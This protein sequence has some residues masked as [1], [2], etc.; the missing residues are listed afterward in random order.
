MWLQAFKGTVPLLKQ[1]AKP[2]LVHHQTCLEDVRDSSTSV[3]GCDVL[4]P[5]AYIILFQVEGV[6][7]GYTHA[8]TLNGACKSR[9]CELV[10]LM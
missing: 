7:V 10:I 6:A 2:L 4:D 3:Y 1:R 5:P 8:S 9:L